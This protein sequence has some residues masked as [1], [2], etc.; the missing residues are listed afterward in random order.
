MP[1][2]CAAGWFQVLASEITPIPD[3]TGKD[4]AP[5]DFLS[6]R[7]DDLAAIL[8]RESGVRIGIEHSQRSG[9]VLQ[10][11][12]RPII[13]TRR[14]C[15]DDL[16]I[17]VPADQDKRRLRRNAAQRLVKNRNK[18]A[19]AI[20]V[21]PVGLGEIVQAGKGEGNSAI[22]CSGVG[23]EEEPTEQAR[24]AVFDLEVGR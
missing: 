3:A 4:D 15:C 24:G 13:D 18:R 16:P 10:G 1:A 22:P 8:A 17:L 6:N 11:R 7:R 19:P 9:F 5:G 14:L 2:K 12:F 23:P 20:G 21:G